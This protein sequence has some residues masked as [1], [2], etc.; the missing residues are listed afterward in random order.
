MQGRYFDDW[1]RSYYYRPG[2]WVWYQGRVWEPVR[3][4][5]SVEIGLSPLQAPGLWVDITARIPLN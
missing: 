4:L 5:S 3:P 2:Q 1:H